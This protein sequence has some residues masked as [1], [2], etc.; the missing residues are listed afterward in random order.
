MDENLFP[1]D[2]KNL[3]KVL[4]QLDQGQS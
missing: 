3:N 1:E 4:V 2:I